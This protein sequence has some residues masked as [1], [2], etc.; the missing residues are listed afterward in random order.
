MKNTVTRG[1]RRIAIL[2]KIHGKTFFENCLHNC[3]SHNYD[4]EY[5]IKAEGISSDSQSHMHF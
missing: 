1:S 4:F 5:C 3:L 2:Y